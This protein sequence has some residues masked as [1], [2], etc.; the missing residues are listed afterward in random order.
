M[1]TLDDPSE[2]A[3]YAEREELPRMSFG[4]HLDELRKRLLRSVIAVVVAIL[5]MVPFHDRVMT[6]I[7]EPYRILWRQGF[8]LHLADWERRDLAGDPTIKDVLHQQMLKFAREN[9]TAILDGTF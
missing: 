5:A 7:I 6:V 8:E 4:D 1:A 3:A 2:R 9:K